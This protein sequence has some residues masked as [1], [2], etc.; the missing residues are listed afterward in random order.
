M[1]NSIDNICICNE[2]EIITQYK[3]EKVYNN[4]NTN[5]NSKKEFINNKSLFKKEIISNNNNFTNKNKNKNDN[6]HNINNLK[7]IQSNALILNKI[8]YKNRNRAAL[9]ITKFFREVKI[10][11]SLQRLMNSINNNNNDN[12]NNSPNKE[13]K[14]INKLKIEFPK[15][16]SKSSTTSEEIYSGNKSNDNNN[17]FNNKQTHLFYN[18][19]E[20]SNSI[21]NNNINNNIINISEKYKFIKDFQYENSPSIFLGT[22]DNNK[23]KNG[24]GLQIFYKNDKDNNIVKLLEKSAKYFGNFSNGFPNGYGKFITINKNHTKN[25][26]NNSNIKNKDYI[27]F[28]TNNSIDN[29]PNNN[30]TITNNN[31]IISNNNTDNN[32]NINTNKNDNIINNNN[33]NSNENNINTNNKIINNIIE[34]DINKIFTQY[35][36]G[37]FH[38]SCADGFGIYHHTLN[39]KYI[40]YWTKDYQ[41]ILGSETWEDNS[42]Y[43]GQYNKGKKNG[44]GTYKW[45][46]GSYYKGEWKNNTLNGY[47]ILK[48][49]YNNNNDSNH[50]NNSI[51][52]NNKYYIGEFKNN[53]KDGLGEII[54]NNKK[55]LGY[56]K[57]N[58]KN[59]FGIIYWFAYNKA[60]IG[61]W[62]EGKQIGLGKC[63]NGNLIQFGF[64]M[65]NGKVIWIEGKEVK[66]ILNEK[67]MERY[68]RFFGFSV[69][70]I[71]N[72]FDVNDFEDLIDFRY[73]F[74]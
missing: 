32:N 26:I 4:N 58:K 46:N 15:F 50:N 57:N 73:N 24:F 23:K 13:E 21:N 56:F 62:K 12:N 34:D 14:S 9:K 47:G 49:N 20:N 63:L 18:I 10:K 8:K 67:S 42:F 22:Y 53:L 41:D 51:N 74:Y 72:F 44:I 54:Q 59:G 61:F 69:I 28:N 48:Y 68:K 60:F 71:K 55:F 45:K 16:N 65:E 43:K 27:N 5:I 3:F 25:N 52:L 35:Y 11:N 37:H 31:N 36:E 66:K 64:W 2:N 38:N 1:G 29:N 40:G 70:N 33:I 39:S 30:S 6:I 19:I 7:I 17:N